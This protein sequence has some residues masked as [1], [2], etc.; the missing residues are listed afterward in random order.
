MSRARFNDL[1]REAREGQDFQTNA[2]RLNHE[3]ISDN[4]C[5]PQDQFT[6]RTKGGP[7]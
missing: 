2:S 1:V 3:S 5:G 4:M 7:R 6:S